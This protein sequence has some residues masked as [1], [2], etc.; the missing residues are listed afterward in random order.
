MKTLAELRAENLPHATTLGVFKV[1]AKA[2]TTP[3]E[4]E[5]NER[6]LAEVV[7]KVDPYLAAFVPVQDHCICC[8]RRLVG[9]MLQAAMG[10][11]T[12]RW[13]LVYG[14]GKCGACG[15]PCRARHEVGGLHWNTVLQYHP[16][17][18]EEPGL[19]QLRED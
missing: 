16:D 10:M 2:N 17:T 18:F 1:R 8:G 13:G 7:A 15:W 14:E 12:F 11:T 4:A 5:A 9:E 6:E 3:K 19:A